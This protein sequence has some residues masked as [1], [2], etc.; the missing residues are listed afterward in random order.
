MSEFSGFPAEALIFFDGLEA[1]N[2]KAYWTDHREVYETA[3][4]GPMLALLDALEPEFGEPHVFRPYRDV[5]FSK[6]KSPYKTAIGAHC[7]RGGYVQVSANGLMAASGYWRTAPDQVERLRAA[8][9]DDL[10]GPGLE[11]L[12]GQLRAAGYDV[13]G[14]VL[15]TRPRGYDADHPRIELLRHKTLTAHREFGEPP[16]LAE[17]S[18]VEQVATAWRDMRR[19]TSWLDDHVGPSRLPESRRR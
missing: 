14:T 10:L 17:P 18:C 13:S 8:I 4:R 3:V 2:S 15:K 11:A 1:D 16:W 7:D 19:L 12:V 5:R 6:D 9:A